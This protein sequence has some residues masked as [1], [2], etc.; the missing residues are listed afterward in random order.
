MS[1]IS[2]LLIGGALAVASCFVQTGVPL[3]GKLH[4]TPLP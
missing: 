3:R 1:R 4:C 2:L